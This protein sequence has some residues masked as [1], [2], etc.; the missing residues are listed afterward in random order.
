MYTHSSSTSYWRFNLVL[1]FGEF[2]YEQSLN[3]HLLQVSLWKFCSWKDL[4]NFKLNIG[5]NEFFILTYWVVFTRTHFSA[6]LKR[7]CKIQVNIIRGQIKWSY[8]SNGNDQSTTTPASCALFRLI[9][10]FTNWFKLLIPI[11]LK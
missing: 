7:L 8:K 2:F 10:Y 9:R 5:F 6:S 4:P 3:N 1:I 11:L